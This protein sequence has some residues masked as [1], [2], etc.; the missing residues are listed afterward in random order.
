MASKRTFKKQIEL[1]CGEVAVQALINLPREKAHKI[2]LELAELQSTTLS[3]MSFS[4]DHVRKDFPN[5]AEYRKALGNYNHKAYK[6][7][8]DDFKDKLKQIIAEMNAALTPEQREANKISAAD[9]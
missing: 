8:E 3:N 9:K 6:K 7:L 4:F 1:I 5:P 2:V